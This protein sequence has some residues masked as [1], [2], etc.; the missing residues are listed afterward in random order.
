MAERRSATPGT[1][2]MRASDSLPSRPPGDLVLWWI[3]RDIRLEDNEALHAA[4]ADARD[5]GASLLPIYIFDAALIAYPDF[6]WFHL[7]A[8]SGALS[9]LTVELRRR[10]VET[11]VSIA[12]VEQVLDQ[13]RPV[14]IWAHEE[15]GLDGSYRRDE[16]IR[17]IAGER[18]IAL[19][20]LPRNGTVRRLN[21]RDQRIA[22]VRRRFAASVREVPAE[23]PQAPAVARWVAAGGTGVALGVAAP[24]A[25][26]EQIVRSVET[27]RRAVDGPVPDP[28]AGIATRRNVPTA[29]VPRADAGG[30]LFSATDLG[31]SVPPAPHLP[32]RVDEPAA[33]VILDSLL[34]SRGH[35]YSRGMSSPVSAPMD[36]S[37][38]SVHLAWGT[39]SLRTAMQ[40]VR[41]R[42]DDLRGR[43]TASVVDGGSIGDW[44]RGLAAVEKRLYW[45]DHFIQRLEDEPETEFVP[46]NRAFEH[47]EEAGF[48]PTPAAEYARR[49]D[50]WLTG[51]TGFPMVDACVRAFRTTGYLP[52]RMRAMIVSFATHVLRLSWR[53]ILYP[54]AG[55][56]ADYVPGIHVSQ[57]Q[58]QA[59]LTGINTIRVYNPVKQLG[60]HDPD[61]R[62]VRWWVP[63]LATVPVAT[64][65][66]LPAV[67]VTGYP[68]PVVDY[69]AESA[70]A[71]RILYGIKGSPAGRQEAARVLERHGSRKGGR[72]R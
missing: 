63:E 24:A 31:E 36:A 26:A 61:A 7:N 70:T 65:R 45:H 53:D 40:A 43:A 39:I 33:R 62:F 17:R 4:A 56:M 47:L 34:R 22:I 54:L 37:R 51:T 59:A 13:L 71:K 32:Q 55:W 46:I 50:A 60:D 5:R 23:I 28:R 9:N 72:S 49:L 41:Q 21:S 2:D 19:S 42:R 3:K 69:R 38:L 52:F 27:A 35:R 58:M 15:T 66:Q 67:A 57:L 14:A 48:F 20:E 11:A 16:T 10:E 18:G 1:S 44:R 29:A 68:P 64:I 6:S 30:E 8:I 25:I 12:P